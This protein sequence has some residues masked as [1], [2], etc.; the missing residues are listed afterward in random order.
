L[1]QND[2]TQ[3]MGYAWKLAV[4]VSYIWKT[5]LETVLWLLLSCECN[6]NC[7]GPNIEC[8]QTRQRPRKY[9]S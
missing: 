1:S 4:V 9:N 5:G 7:S 6:C 2:P 8:K 3:C